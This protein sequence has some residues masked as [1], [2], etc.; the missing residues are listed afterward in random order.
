MKYFWNNRRK[1]I[2]FLCVSLLLFVGCQPSTK[3]TK[4]LKV[5]TTAYA[6]ASLLEAVAGDSIELTYVLTGDA[7]HVE[8]TAED[9]KKIAQSDLFVNVEIGDYIR[10]GQQIKKINPQMQ[11]VDVA[12]GIELLEDSGHDHSDDDDDNHSDDDNHDD[13]HNDDDHDDDATHADALLMNPHIWLDPVRTKKIVENIEH[14]LSD[15]LPDQKQKFSENAK[16]T[17]EMLTKLDET[18][19]IKF[20]NLTQKH[21]FVTHAAYTY[22]AHR[23]QLH[24]HAIN[25]ASDHSENTQQSMITITDEIKKTN[26]KTIFVEENLAKGNVV[27]TLVK[28]N[29][30][31]IQLVSNIETQN[32]QTYLELMEKNFESFLAGLSA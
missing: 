23:Y 15:K 25:S 5:A 4:K 27:D 8:L 20:K 12:E 32:N 16:K 29:Q 2:I 13:D 1:G 22:F 19:S 9:A 3:S 24:Q 11:G 10:I 21:F 14:T 6:L 26:T 30:L 31:K 17:N 28:D 18:Y 7:H